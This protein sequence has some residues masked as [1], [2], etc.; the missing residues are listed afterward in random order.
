MIRSHV[1]REDDEGNIS[2]RSLFGNVYS[3]RSVDGGN[4]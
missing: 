2:F 4:A 1:D 3:L